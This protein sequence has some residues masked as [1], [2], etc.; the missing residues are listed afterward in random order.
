MGR[1]ERSGSGMNP[2]Y[3]NLALWM[4]IGLVVVL[5][6][7]V[8]SNLNE[9]GGVEPSYSDFVR[10]VESRPGGVGD[11][12]GQPGARTPEGRGG[13]PDVHRGLPGPGQDDARQGRPDQRQAPRPEPLVHVGAAL[14]VPDDPVHRR[15]DLLHA[16]DAGGRRQGA[17]V[18]QG[19]GPADLR[20][21]QQGDLRGR[22]RR[23]GGQGRAAGDHRVPQG[24]PAVPEAGREDSQGRPP[25]GPARHRQDPAGQGDR[26]RGERPVLL[27]L[28]V[29]LRGDVR[30]GRRLAG[31]G[32]VRA[33][34][35]A[36]A[37]HHLHGRDRRGGPSPRAPGWAAA[38]TSGSRR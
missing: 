13:V 34:E 28:G 29:R 6:F 35:E 17:L 27:D 20:E 36:R 38:T 9:K 21:A 12:P 33:G 1:K 11:D 4:V 3:K 15:L 26:R 23:R 30:R 10:N 25:G 5:L 14:V 7:N 8:F 22:R 37:L 32:P 19:P 24:S 2:F 16:T 18:R 31:P